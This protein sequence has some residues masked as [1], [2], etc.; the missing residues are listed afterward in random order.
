MSKVAGLIFQI[1]FFLQIFSYRFSGSNFWVESFVSEVLGLNFPVHIF[2]YKFFQE[3]DVWSPNTLTYIIL[4]FYFPQQ[5]FVCRSVEYNYVT[6]QVNHITRPS[7]NIVT[8][9]SLWCWPSHAHRRLQTTGASGR[10][11][12]WLLWE[13]VPCGRDNLRRSKDVLPTKD[14]SARRQDF[15]ARQRSLLHRQ[16]ECRDK[17]LTK[18]YSKQTFVHICKKKLW[19]YRCFI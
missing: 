8:V 4:I 17:Y 10:P 15:H 2:G 14:R 9:S 1:H 11:R 7:I 18:L 5:N 13:P 19:N 3:Q 12:D 16:G 6:L